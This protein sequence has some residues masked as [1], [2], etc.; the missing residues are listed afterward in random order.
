VSVEQQVVL[1]LLHLAERLSQ[2]MGDV[3]LPHQLTLPQYGVLQALDGAGDE[4]LACGEIAAR[5]TTRD[6]DITRLLDRLEARGLVARV[7]AR[8]DRRIVRSLLTREGRRVVAVLA[9]EMRGVH[10]EHLGALKRRDL[11]T[12][13]ALLGAA[14]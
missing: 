4:G 2:R 1:Q 6:P 10:A 8:P 5:L 14:G 9:E 11:G 7:R 13:H 12:L 3:L